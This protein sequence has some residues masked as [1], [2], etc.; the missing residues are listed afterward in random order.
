MNCG[1]MYGCVAMLRMEW[2]FIEI[3]ARQLKSEIDGLSSSS[4]LI[5]PLL[6]L[7]E[8]LTQPETLTLHLNAQNFT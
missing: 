4:T 5:L 8:T 2:R 1:G 6:S 7:Q 3:G